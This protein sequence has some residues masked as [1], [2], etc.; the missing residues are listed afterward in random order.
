MK[1][2][3][4][5]PETKKKAFFSSFVHEYERTQV[6]VY[7]LKLKINK[8]ITIFCASFCAEMNP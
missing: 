7:G 8:K 5:A 1:N 6:I 2:C 4:K 3:K